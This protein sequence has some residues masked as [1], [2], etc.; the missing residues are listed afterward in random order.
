LL[1]SFPLFM[2]INVIPGFG[3]FELSNRFG[4]M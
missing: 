1:F 3:S 4:H 2:K